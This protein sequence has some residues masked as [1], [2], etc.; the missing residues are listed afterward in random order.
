MDI[1]WEGRLPYVTGKNGVRIS[2][3]VKYQELGGLID[4][5]VVR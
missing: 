4:E 1:G 3:H 2:C 5:T